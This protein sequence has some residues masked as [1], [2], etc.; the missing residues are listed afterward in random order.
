MRI[1]AIVLAGL[2]AA[3]WLFAVP[4][5]SSADPYPQCGRGTGVC[6][7]DSNPDHWCFAA[8]TRGMPA[9]RESMQWAINKAHS[10]T[11]ISTSP[12]SSCSASADVR[13]REGGGLSDQILGEYRC[14][15]WAGPA[16]PEVCYASDVVINRSAHTY[17]ADDPDGVVTHSDGRIEAGEIELNLDMSA[18]HELGHHLGLAHHDLGWYSTFDNDCMRSPWLEAE[19]ASEGWRKYNKHH[20]DHIDDH[21]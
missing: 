8:D 13:W 3:T 18:C 14:T 17:Y 11:A 12:M 5:V 2:L 7:P 9:V 15:D 10:T 16:H 21:Y 20:R 1:R 19:Q 6:R 4:S